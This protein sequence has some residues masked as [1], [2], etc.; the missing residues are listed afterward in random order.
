MRSQDPGTV[1]IP[2]YRFNKNKATHTPP[3]LTLQLFLDFPV[4]LFNF[5]PGVAPNFLSASNLAESRCPPGGVS[6][7]PNQERLG[8]FQESWV[9]RGQLGALYPLSRQVQW[10][11]WV[12][13]TQER[14]K[15]RT[16]RKMTPPEEQPPIL[17]V[18]L[19]GGFPRGFSSILGVNLGGCSS[20]GFHFL[21]VLGLVTS[22]GVPCHVAEVGR[23]FCQNTL[24]QDPP[25]PL[26][27]HTPLC[28]AQPFP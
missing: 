11:R 18:V 19:Q 24:C 12:F 1:T 16:R 2:Q 3:P 23:G 22:T 20:G 6:L 7:F 10:L 9:L 26:D 15:E 13:S 5:F 4:F 17:G 28:Q 14:K 21:W 8:Q 25:L 27:L